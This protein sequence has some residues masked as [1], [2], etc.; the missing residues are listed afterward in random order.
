MTFKRIKKLVLLFLIRLVSIIDRIINNKWE[1][2][3]IEE[4]EMGLVYQVSLPPVTAV[5]LSKRVL[6][7][8]YGDKTSSIE[9]RPN[10]VSVT[11][12]PVKEGEVVDLTLQDFDDAG[13]SSL[14]SDVFSFTAKDTLP[15]AKPGQVSVLLVEEVADA[16]PA[17]VVEGDAVVSPPSQS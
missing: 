13:N 9:L 10:D 12:A 2:K 8:K 5:D 11:L 4:N 14:P 17:N 15:P 1:Y 16:P 7:I 3:L 6:T